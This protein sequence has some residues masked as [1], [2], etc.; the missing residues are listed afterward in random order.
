MTTVPF[1]VPVE[2]VDL[3]PDSGGFPGDVLDGDPRM[4]TAVLWAAADRA[5]VRGVWECEPG[6]FTWNFPRNETLVVLRGHARV[7]V[8]DG[9][10][11]DLSPGTVAAF[12]TGDR[13]VWEVTETLRKVFVVDSAT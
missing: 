6:R 4:S 9:P 13:T 2:D 10:E 8:G 12:R 1:A 7:R 11:L 3:T 5:V